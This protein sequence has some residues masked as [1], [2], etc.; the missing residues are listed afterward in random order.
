[1]VSAYSGV[2]WTSPDPHGPHPDCLHLLPMIT[3]RTAVLI[4]GLDVPGF[5]VMSETIADGVPDA[6]LHV[7]PD[8]GHMVNMEAPAAVNAVLLDMIRFARGHR[9]DAGPEHEAR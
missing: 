3:C 4:G 8:A 6:R 5:R 9:D 2:H 7:V 1:M